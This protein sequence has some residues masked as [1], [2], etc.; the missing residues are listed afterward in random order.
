ML[1]FQLWEFYIHICKYLG[2]LEH[3]TIKDS[4]IKSMITAKYKVTKQRA[5]K[6]LKS[7]LN[8]KNVITAVAKHL[9]RSFDYLHSWNCTLDTD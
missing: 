4:Q 1:L 8:G 9:G 6:V 7:S 3:D 2:L 5:R